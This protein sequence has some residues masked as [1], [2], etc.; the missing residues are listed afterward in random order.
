MAT[1]TIEII[2]ENTGMTKSY[3]K[4]TT[5]DQIAAD[6]NIQLKEPVLG[7]L[8]NN[9]LRELCYDVYKP[10]TVQFVDMTHPIGYRMYARSLAFIMYKAVMDMWPEATLRIEHSVS[11]GWYCEIDNVGIII[12][13]ENV[14]ELEKKMKEIVMADI[15]F[16]RTEVRTEKAIALFQERQMS[17]KA[18]LFGTRTDMYTSIYSLGDQINYFYGYLVPSTRYIHTFDLIPFNG[19]LLLRLPERHNPHHLPPV[20]RQEKLF[21]IFR[22]HKKWGIIMKVPYVGNL[23]E[24][25]AGH[26]ES[27]LIQVAEA[28]HEKKVARIA[29]KIFKRR[30]EVKII[31]I[32]GPSSSGKTTFS[33]RLGVQLS[34]LGFRTRLISIDDYF[35]D[36][37]LTPRDENGDYD[38]E[39]IKAINVEKFNQDLKDLIDGRQIELPRFDFNEGKSK[40]SGKILQLGDNDLLIVEGIHGLNPEL[41]PGIKP[42]QKFKVFVSALTQISIDT[43]NPIPSTDNRL[44][45]RI[46]RDY[47]YRGYSALNTLRRWD[48]VRAG[49]EANIFPFQEQADIMFNSA[50]FYELAVLKTMA[51]PILK[52]VQQNVPEYAEAVRLLKFLSFFRTIGSKEIPPTSILREFLGGSSF[53]Y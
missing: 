48:S 41:T 24:A 16:T 46:V 52:E 36:R 47:Q 15:P 29:D 26:H 34:V 1:N 11:K 35:V 19:G 45:R 32:S 7:A 51:E 28:L 2:C 42:G 37:E 6:Q 9:K 23:N 18:D 44:I 13:P 50:L 40:L 49:E 25:V 10:K 33:K 4:G 3:T 20:P 22:E 21:K 12:K 14:E 30:H 53:I 43:Q 39:T 17:D 27:E 38:F 8:I 31:L 5:L